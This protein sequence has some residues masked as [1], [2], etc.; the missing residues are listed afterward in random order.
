LCRTL[1]SKELAARD[2]SC[3]SLALTL[4]GILMIFRFFDF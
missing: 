2:H 4:L 1:V 3:K